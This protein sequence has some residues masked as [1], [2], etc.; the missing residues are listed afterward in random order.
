MATPGPPPPPR[1][2]SARS[3][4]EGAASAAA[5]PGPGGGRGGAGPSL[6]A[7]AASSPAGSAARAACVLRDVSA[8]RRSLGQAPPPRSGA[9]RLRAALEGARGQRGAGRERAWGG[10]GDLRCGR[11]SPPAPDA[12]FRRPRAAP[13]PNM[14]NAP[15]HFGRFHAAAPCGPH[16]TGAPLGLHVF[17]RQQGPASLR[18]GT[19]PAS[20]L[21]PSKLLS[22]WGR[23]HPGTRLEVRRVEDRTQLK[24]R[25]VVSLRS[26]PGIQICHITGLTRY[27]TKE[28]N[29]FYI[30]KRPRVRR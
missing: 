2:P 3:A 28:I 26:A 21:E 4:R 11:P 14:D 7:P 27:R 19:G 15:A 29:L 9:Q 10:R 25:S 23:G 6:P 18:S 5:G 13:P 22:H 12:L 30:R 16:P 17:L 24:H 20:P 8:A 1:E